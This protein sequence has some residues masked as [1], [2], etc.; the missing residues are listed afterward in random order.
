VLRRAG[1]ESDRAEPLGVARRA[2]VRPCIGALD[3]GRLLRRKACEFARA[4]QTV[5]QRGCCTTDAEQLENRQEALR[6]RLNV[7]A[8][9]PIM[10][11]LVLAPRAGAVAEGTH[12]GRFYANICS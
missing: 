10:T 1:D 8:S 11:K 5:T 7:T 12:G 4:Q 3:D 9:A 2:L 6:S